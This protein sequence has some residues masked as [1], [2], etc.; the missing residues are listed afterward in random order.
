MLKIVA[1]ECFK[2][3]FSFFRMGDPN[4]QNNHH[5]DRYSNQR[6]YQPYVFRPNFM[7]NTDGQTKQYGRK[8]IDWTGSCAQTIISRRFK[9]KRDFDKRI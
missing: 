2:K 1:T 5:N 4:R 8:V 7:K 6:Q 3:I 9:E